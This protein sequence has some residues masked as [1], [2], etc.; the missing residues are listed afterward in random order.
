MSSV[1][2]RKYRP[3]R[4]G[5]IIGQ[6]HIV[7]TLTNALK[8]NSMAHS[9]LFA[10]PRGVGK[11]TIARLLAKAVNCTDRKSGDDGTDTAEPCEKC[12]Q[13]I[14]YKNGQIID[15][16]EIDAASHTGVDKVREY[17]IDNV[18][19]APTSSKYKVFIIDEVHMLSTS[20]FNA[21]LKTLEEPPEHVIFILATTEAHKLLATIRSRCEE[22]SFRRVGHG[23]IKEKMLRILKDESREVDEKVLNRIAGLSEGCLRDAE[24]LLGQVLSIKDG[25]ISVSDCEN[26]LPKLFTDEAVK[27]LEAVS[28][29]NASTGLKIIFEL[30]NVAINF[31]VFC[32]H[33]IDLVRTTMLIKFDAANDEELSVYDVETMDKMRKLAVGFSNN[34]FVQILSKFLEA[35]TKTPSAPLPNL[36]LEMAIVELC[37]DG[38]VVAGAETRTEANTRTTTDVQTNAQEVKAEPKPNEPQPL[39]QKTSIKEKVGEVVEEVKEKIVHSFHGDIKSSVED[40]KSRWSECVSLVQKENN[41]LS[42]V[43]KM[44]EP[45]KI[46]GCKLIVNLPF[47]FHADK[48]KEIKN[49]ACV[50]D[51]LKELFGERIEL[52]CVV[53]DGMVQDTAT[54]FGSSSPAVVRPSDGLKPSEAPKDLSDLA[55]AFGGEVM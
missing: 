4:W 13:C 33:L 35:R 31:Y 7:Q 8:K 5:D 53:K 26:I 14:A 54:A 28:E 30:D 47:S 10:G 3:Q 40:I 43:L 24:S 44:A 19:F 45:A 6:D 34:N 9:F 38:Q 20:A 23:L 15:V 46:E 36:P 51:A 50:E 22:Y 42:F 12:P 17:V 25:K 18:Q 16:I 11:T 37:D 52:D 2:Y 21:L 32:T 1:L 41:S 29:K 49:K 48:I 27:I 55:E 39:A